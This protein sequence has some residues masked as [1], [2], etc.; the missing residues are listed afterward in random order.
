M[1][2]KWSNIGIYIIEILSTILFVSLA[3]AAFLMS[4]YVTDAYQIVIQRTMDNILLNIVYLVVFL[5][6]IMGT[7]HGILH[8][9][10][11]KK[12]LLGLVCMWIFTASLLW[13]YFSKSGPASDCGSVYYAAKQFARND[14][15]AL[16]Y[17]GSYFSVYPFQLG[18]AFFYEIIIR[19]AH[20]DN[21]HVLQGANAVCLVVC[22]ISQ[23]Q[24]TGLFFSGDKKDK[25]QIYELLL[26]FTCIPY[27]MYGS[28]IYG[29]IPSFAFVLF[30]SWMLLLMLQENK[31]LC[32]IPGF[33]SIILGVMVRKNTLIFMIALG[34]IIF[35]YYLCNWKIMSGKKKVGL[36][37][38]FS[39]LFLLAVQIIPI[40]QNSYAERSGTVINS[41]VPASDYLAMGLMEADAGPGGYNGYN[42]ETFT[43]TANY[44]TETAAEIGWNAYQERLQYFIGHPKYAILFFGEKFLDQWLNPGWAIFNST[45]VSFG[46]RPA[47]IESCFSGPLYQVLIDYMSNYQMVLYLLTALSCLSLLSGRNKKTEG[48]SV[49]VLLFLLTAIGGAIFYL[50]WEASG[51][52]VLPYAIWVLPNAASGFLMLERLIEKIRRKVC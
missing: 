42:F 9:K 23:Y 17:S 12:Y 25:I 43:E 33:L 50:A 30:G 14:F 10:K 47:I 37:L 34:C 7:T 44:D 13:S 28:Y 45:Y 38:Y 6:I 4:A 22:V 51:R 19:I 32:A 35:L 16:A 46:E 41:G 36:A 1:T 39:C 40:I 49:F 29:E 11:G 8:F 18:L 20:S 24:L 48:A 27:M 31:W 21:F 52:Y 15:S 5:A 26:T 2:V 3:I